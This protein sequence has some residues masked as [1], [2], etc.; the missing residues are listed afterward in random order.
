MN[1]NLRK[2]AADKSGMTMIELIITTV[3]FAV[4]LIALNSVFF[5]SNRMYSKTNQRVGIQ[6]NSRLGMSIMTTEIRHAGCD[7]TGMGVA[8]VAMASADSIRISADLDGDGAISTAEPSEDVTYFFDSVA[9]TLNRDPGTGAQIIVP[10]VS[11]A[12]FTYLDGNNNALGPMPLDAT[13][14]DQ[15]RTVMVS[16]TS[17]SADAGDIT[18]TTSIALRNP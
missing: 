2:L 11:A 5:G 1:V 10:N 3:V 4:V 8:A 17:T 13:L 18:L 9:G 16:L 12:T 15:V 14:V 7:P 6:M